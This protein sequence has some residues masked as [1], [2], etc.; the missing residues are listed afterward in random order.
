[1]SPSPHLA[2]AGGDPDPQPG[3]DGQSQ[4]ARQPRTNLF[5]SAQL[6]L[7]GE[8]SRPVRVRNLS[9]SGARIDLP[10][11]PPRGSTLLL[12]RGAAEVAA[13]VMWSAGSSCGLRFT[14]IIDVARWMPDRPGAAAPAK[15]REPSLA[16]ELALARRLVDR[17][18]DALSSEP[19]VVAAL[20]KELQALDLLGQL[21][22]SSEKRA[23]GSTVPAIRSLWQ[24]IATFLRTPPASGGRA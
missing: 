15:A 3:N 20:G 17:L 13:E 14:E 6:S 9:A 22:A 5:L 16:E 19:A 10:Q 18:E 1:M 2:S 23:A 12:C 4:P 11:P 21:L 7:P 8:A 24:A